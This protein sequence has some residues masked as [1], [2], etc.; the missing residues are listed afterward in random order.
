MTPLA[1][2]LWVLNITFD[3][4]GQLAFKAA[5]GTPDHL[6]GLER[7]KHMLGDRWLWLGISAYVVEIFCWIAFLS[8]VPLSV[9]VLLG[10]I[11]ILAVML[12]GRIFFGEALTTRRLTATA[13]ITVGVVLVGWS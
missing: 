13:L 12:G 4:I 1:T 10:S 8:M 9:A 5:A 2:L 11:N 3:A 7:W 6:D